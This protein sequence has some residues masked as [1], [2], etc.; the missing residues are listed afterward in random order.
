MLRG[1]ERGAVVV[2]VGGAP[3][4]LIPQP[5][6]TAT[7]GRGETVAAAVVSVARRWWEGLAMLGTLSLQR[8][9]R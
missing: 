6:D 3:E 5:Q 8:A 7:L 1:L 2:N 9:G 4:T